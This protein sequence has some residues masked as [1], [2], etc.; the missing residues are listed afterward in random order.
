MGEWQSIE[1]APKGPNPILAGKYHA[2]YGW[3]W[4]RVRWYESPG[5]GGFYAGTELSDPTHWMPLPEPPVTR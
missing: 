5:G 2:V 1:T 4:G 3:L